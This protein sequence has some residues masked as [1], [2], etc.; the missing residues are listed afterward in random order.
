LLVAVAVA[1]AVAL[2]V[3]LA[4]AVK[5]VYL[6]S[7][8]TDGLVVVVAV[9]EQAL[10]ILLVVQQDL[11]PLGKEVGALHQALAEQIV[12]LAVAVLAHAHQT[13]QL[14]VV[15]AVSVAD[16]VLVELL[17]ILEPLLL[18]SQLALDQ[19]VAQEQQFLE[20]A[21][22]LGTVLELV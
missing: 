10:Q 11:V 8:L 20:T 9:V 15:T 21:T 2:T 7:F 3:T 1:V 16:G 18:P 22:L 13:Q 6:L 5:Q 19:V 12:G 14:V 4:A 17:E